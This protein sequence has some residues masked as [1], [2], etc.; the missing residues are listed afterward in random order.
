VTLSV[1]A[2]ITLL[3]GEYP[4]MLENEMTSDF[5][6]LLDSDDATN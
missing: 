4:M 1:E 6:G 5:G 2:L 3:A